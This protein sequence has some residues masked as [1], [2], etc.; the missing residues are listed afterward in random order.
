MLDTDGGRLAVKYNSVA[1]KDM[2]SRKSIKIPESPRQ[3][4]GHSILFVFKVHFVE[5]IAMMKLAQKIEFENL[6]AS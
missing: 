4:H 3:T 2:H 1:R 5:S 6:D